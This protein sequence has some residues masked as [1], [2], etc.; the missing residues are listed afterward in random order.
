MRFATRREWLKSSVERLSGKC[1][2][3]VMVAYALRYG[4]QEIPHGSVRRRMALHPLASSRTRGAR[5][6]QA[7]RLAADPGCRLLRAKERLS[8]ATSAE[9]LPALEDRLR[10]VQEMAHRWDLEEPERRA[11]RGLARTAW[12]G[13]QAQRGDSGLSVGQDHRGRRTRSRLQ[14]RKEGGRQ[15]APLSRGH[16]GFGARSAGSQRQGARPGRHKA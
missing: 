4:E 6:P 5:T 3:G 16:R 2:G 8:L 13:S 14:P 11:A 7:S 10:L 9:G 12:Q 15:E 1:A